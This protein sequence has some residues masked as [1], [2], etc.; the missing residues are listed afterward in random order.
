M[1]KSFYY[2]LIIHLHKVTF[3]D[4]L[5]AGDKGFAMGATNRQNVTATDFFAVWVGVNS[6]DGHL[7]LCTIAIEKYTTTSAS[8]SK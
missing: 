2:S 5:I 6:Y 4:L 7:L 8:N 1:T 3:P